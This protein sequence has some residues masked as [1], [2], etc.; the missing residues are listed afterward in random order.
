MRTEGLTAALILLA[1]SMVVLLRWSKFGQSELQDAS[2]SSGP[3]DNFRLADHPGVTA[4]WLDSR[5]VRQILRVTRTS[6]KSRDARGSRSQTRDSRN[7]HAQRAKRC[8]AYELCSACFLIA[9]S[10]PEKIMA[11]TGYNPHQ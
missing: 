4:W 6:G 8:A 11:C 3:Q 10:M 9:L 2:K 1:L 5:R 7:I